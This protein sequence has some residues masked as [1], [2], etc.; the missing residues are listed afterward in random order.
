MAR[1]RKNQPASLKLG[2]ALR[3]FVVCLV[4]GGSGVGFVLQKNKIYDL[5]QL[6]KRREVELDNLSKDNDRWRDQ[7]RGLQLPQRLADR[8]RQ[9][10]L[11]L[12]PARPE[13]IIWLPEPASQAQARV[14]MLSQSKAPS[15]E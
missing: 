1:N 6:K 2:A 7:L 8:V 11:G 9:L 12:V 10:N 14:L 5:G 3:V 15:P 13:Q 4:L